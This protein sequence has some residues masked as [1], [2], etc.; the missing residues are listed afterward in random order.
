MP[1]YP[2]PPADPA[3]G[4]LARA[5]LATLVNLAATPG[6]GSLMAGRWLAGAGQLLLA[7]AGAVLLGWWMIGW[8][9]HF[10]APMLDRAAAAPGHG[11]G[12]TGLALLAAGWLWA[13]ATSLDL[14]RRARRI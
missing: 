9:L 8:L 12:L 2:Q 10:A 6:L 11:R 1:T 7:L 14:L 13:L 5:R 4:A 3:A